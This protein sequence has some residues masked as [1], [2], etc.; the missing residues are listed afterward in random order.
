MSKVLALVSGGIDSI[1]LAYFLKAKGYEV[2]AIGINYGQKQKIELKYAKLLMEEGKINF[3]ILNIMSLSYLL[4]SS[5]TSNDIQ[6]TDAKST[7]VPNRNAIFLSIALGVALS[8]NINCIAYACHKSDKLNYPDCRWEFVN[9]FT[10]AMQ[11]GNDNPEIQ[12]I[13][14]FVSYTK[15]KIIEAANSLG[16]SLEKTYSCYKGGKIHCG[17][18]PACVERKKSFQEAKVIDKTTYEQ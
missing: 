18:C 10:L 4:T 13:A 11:L 1:T 2:E 14:P 7:V 3:T 8:K 17:I 15:T 6:I 5:L 12:I 16:V 9:A